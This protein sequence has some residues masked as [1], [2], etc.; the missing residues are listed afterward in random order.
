M[1]R[2][3][4]TTVTDT[5]ASNVGRHQTSN[6]G[7]DVYHRA[8]RK[9]QCPLLEQIPCRSTH[10]FSGIGRGVGIRTCPEPDHMSDWQI[11]ERK[12]GGD[13]E[14]Y[15]RELDPLRPGTDDQRT[16]NGGKRTLKHHKGQLGNRHALREGA[17]QCFTRDTLEQDLVERTEEGITFREG[18]AVA[19]HNP[20]QADQRKHDEDLNQQGQYVLLANQTTVEERQPRDGHKNHER[21]TNHDPGVIGLVHD[22]FNCRRFC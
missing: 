18:N 13:T 20:Q 6:S 15:G 16:G 3:G 1:R 4:F 21:R 10:R 22:R 11:G 9:V 14:Q 17:G 5:L 12:P 7:V 19:V 8:S 2:H